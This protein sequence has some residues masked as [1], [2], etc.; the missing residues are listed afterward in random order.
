MLPVCQFHI[1]VLPAWLSSLWEDSIA[2]VLPPQSAVLR[3]CNIPLIFPANVVG[4]QY[5]LCTTYIQ[6]TCSPWHT[7][8][9]GHPRMSLPRYQHFQST[10]KEVFIHVIQRGHWQTKNGS[11]LSSA[12]SVKWF[13]DDNCRRAVGQWH[14]LLWEGSCTA[15]SQLYYWRV[16]P[17]PIVCLYCL[18]IIKAHRPSIGP[19]WTPSGT[20][21]WHRLCHTFLAWAPVCF[22]LQLAGW[23]GNSRKMAH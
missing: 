15:F 19:S 4:S 2:S 14:L 11:C 5:P 6:K 21:S 20:L 3:I 23:E 8:K 22:A 7:R 17:Q 12:W 16:S 1:R 18:Y 9:D 13:I 10:Y